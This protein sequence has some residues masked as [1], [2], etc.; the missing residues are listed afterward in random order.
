VENFVVSEYEN[1]FKEHTNAVG[2]FSPF[3]RKVELADLG[4][5]CLARNMEIKDD[6]AVCFGNETVNISE[7]VPHVTRGELDFICS[8][9]YYLT[10]I[11]QRQGGDIREAILQLYKKA[12]SLGWT[13]MY[14]ARFKGASGTIEQVRPE[15]IMAILYRLKCIRFKNELG[16]PR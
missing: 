15:D 16:S 11:E 7:I 8:F 10:V 12:D 5:I 4:K 2:K 3:P 14:Q 9:I 1:S 13:G 6:A